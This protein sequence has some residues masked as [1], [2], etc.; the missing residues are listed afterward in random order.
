[1]ALDA[2]NGSFRVPE[3]DEETGSVARFQVNASGILSISGLQPGSYTLRETAPPAGCIAM[4]EDIRLTIG[5]NGEISLSENSLVSCT[6]SVITVKNEYAPR[7]LTLEK[8]VLNAN[9]TGKFDFLL[10]YPG[11]DGQ[12]VTHTLSLANGEKSAV[13]IP[14]GV[15][16]TIREAEH[17]GFALTFR[18]G[19]TILESGPDDSFTFRILED[20]TITAVNTAG[21]VLPDT[22]GGGEAVFAVTGT[23]LLAAALI[24]CPRKRRDGK[25]F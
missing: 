6:G 21:Y 1:M 15:N 23:M 18:N 2:G 11:E 17:N 4:M 16:V 5:L 7:V 20:V 9:T 3:T 19:E 22:G 13:S 8:K 24:I 25:Q 10:S 14:Y 12:P